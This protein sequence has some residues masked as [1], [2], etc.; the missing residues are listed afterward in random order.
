[1]YGTIR[2]NYSARRASDVSDNVVE[3]SYREKVKK[4]KRRKKKELLKK[5]LKK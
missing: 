1:M 4:E 5:L 2:K 3:R